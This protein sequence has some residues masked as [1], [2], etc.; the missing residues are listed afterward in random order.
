[1]Q[2]VCNNPKYTEYIPRIVI[3]NKTKPG[4][5]TR[6]TPTC[7][8]TNTRVVQVWTKNEEVLHEI[9]HSLLP[10]LPPIFIIRIS[11]A[12]KHQYKKGCGVVQGADQR[13]LKTLLFFSTQLIQATLLLQ[14]MTPFMAASQQSTWHICERSVKLLE[15]NRWTE[16]CLKE[17]NRLT[18]VNQK[19]T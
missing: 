11:L 7:S 5:L 16:T 13:T 12:G 8:C 18:E 15:M 2:L 1:M 14:N 9:A 4:V 19:N 3:N 6:R 10:R 17:Q